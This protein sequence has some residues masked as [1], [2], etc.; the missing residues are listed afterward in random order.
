M[1]KF[2]DVFGKLRTVDDVRGFLEGIFSSRELRDAERRW[3]AIQLLIEGKSQR[4]ASKAAG[5]SIASIS[6]AASVSRR[7]L[8]LFKKVLASERNVTSEL[9]RRQSTEPTRSGD[10]VVTVSGG[11]LVGWTDERIELL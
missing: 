1:L 9:T 4:A 2:A 10:R 11:A 7:N 5:M 8:H 3:V 6:R